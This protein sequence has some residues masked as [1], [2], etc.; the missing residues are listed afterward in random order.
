MFFYK[1]FKLL[2]LLIINTFAYSCTKL[3]IYNFYLNK[4]LKIESAV[5]FFLNL[6]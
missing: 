1:K 3:R 6:C 2:N 5:Q 4:I